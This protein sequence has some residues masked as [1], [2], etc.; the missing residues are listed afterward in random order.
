MCFFEIDPYLTQKINE[1]VEPVS[2][3]C[4][5]CQWYCKFM[6]QLSAS[7]GAFFV[8]T[9]IDPLKC[10]ELWGYDSLYGYN[11]YTGFFYIAVHK[12]E[13]E[14]QFCITREYKALEYDICRFRIRL[15]ELNTGE[16]ILGFEADLPLPESKDWTISTPQ[17]KW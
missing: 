16:T 17:E 7:A 2:C 14:S 8:E 1:S 13:Q 10:Q 12:T 3:E 6:K 11:H 9:G 5:D 4:P 15:E